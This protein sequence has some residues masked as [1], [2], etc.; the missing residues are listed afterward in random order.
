MLNSIGRMSAV[1][2]LAGAALLSNTTEAR[3]DSIRACTNEENESSCAL[4]AM[5]GYYSSWDNKWYCPVFY[6][7]LWDD[8]HNEPAG[9]TVYD[10]QDDPCYTVLPCS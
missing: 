3:A 6:Y 8:E 7:C 10:S 9:Y 5:S 1:V 2:V 4:M